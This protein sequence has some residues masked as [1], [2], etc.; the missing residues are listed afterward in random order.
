MLARQRII[1]YLFPCIF[2]VAK[3]FF[4]VPALVDYHPLPKY[5]L[6]RSWFHVRRLKEFVPKQQADLTWL[7]CE[8][9]NWKNS[10]TSNKIPGLWQTQMLSGCGFGTLRRYMTWFL[11][12]TEVF[13]CVFPSHYLI[14]HGGRGPRAEYRWRPAWDDQSFGKFWKT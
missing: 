10:F 6:W 12:E 3:V 2:K 9:Q 5:V 11:Q 1:G 4:L 14:S 7:F 8:C 13:C